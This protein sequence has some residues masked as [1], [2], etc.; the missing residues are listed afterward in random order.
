MAE[1][2]K[3]IALTVTNQQRDEALRMIAYVEGEIERVSKGDEDLA[4]R[5]RRFVHARL[6]LKNRGS[7]Q[8]REKLRRGLFDKQQGRCALCDRPFTELLRTH[9]H[10]MGAGRYTEANT[11]LVHQEC[12][13]KHHRSQGELVESDQ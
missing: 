6:Q 4:F 2:E 11:Q 9:L 5:L 10:R 13:E 3:Q 1:N 7:V 8:Q 12:H